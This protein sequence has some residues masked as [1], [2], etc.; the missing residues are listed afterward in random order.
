MSAQI[1]ALFFGSPVGVKSGHRKIEKDLQ[2]S[3]KKRPS[4][5]PQ[6]DDMEREARLRRARVLASTAWAQ[7]YI[8]DELTDGLR[9][10]FYLADVSFGVDPDTGEVGY[11]IVAVGVH[12]NDRMML[13]FAMAVQQFN[14]DVKMLTGYILKI[15]GDFDTLPL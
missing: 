14:A 6:K 4:G 9:D 3:R 13:P 11:I 5:F 7:Q 2:M 10:D 15:L 1:C 8:T 12:A